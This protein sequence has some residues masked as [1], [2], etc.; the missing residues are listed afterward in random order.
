MKLL[1]KINNDN[2]KITLGLISAWI[3]FQAQS[4]ISIDNIGVSVWGWL[5]GGAILG[6]SNSDKGN[7][8][9]SLSN[10]L[11]LKSSSSV[12]INL[13]QPT[14]SVLFLVPIII[15]SSLFY[16]SESNLYFLKNITVP[17][18]PQNIQS[19]LE[20]VNK[21][22]DN[23]FSD[24]F[25]KYRAAIFLSTMGYQDQAYTIIANLY[26]YDPKNPDYLLGLT[27]FEEL[28][29][30]IPNAI[31][32]RNEISDID[33]WNA[34]NYLRLLVLYKNSGDLVNAN[35]MKNKILSFAPNTDI[36]KTASE[37]LG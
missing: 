14:I 5:L 12:N 30:N 11:N 15:F 35:A 28:K 1:R 9:E 13:F 25:Y 3:G 7:L 6:L 23:T 10:S 2:Q 33:P 21:I 16:K 27:Y 24:P 4:L 36:A 34:D 20:Y 18:S 31:S 17:S 8:S 19:V 29:Q 32:L 22:V 37:T 26:S